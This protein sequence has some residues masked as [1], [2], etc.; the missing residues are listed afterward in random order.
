MSELELRFASE[1]YDRIRPLADG[2]VVPR[3]LALGYVRMG[4][5]ELFDRMARDRD[6]HIAEMSLSTYLNFRSRDIDE[7][8]ALPVFTSRVFRHGFI[9]V[10]ADSGIAA[11]EDLRGVRVGTM[12]YQ[13]TSNLWTRGFL[14]DDYGITPAD[15]TWYLGG[16]EE[17]GATER[18]PVAIPDDVSVERIPPEA[19]LCDLLV[20]GEIDA[21]FAPHTPSCFHERPD[22]IRRLFPD[23]R[24]VEQEY[25]RRTGFFPIMHVVVVRRD[26]YDANP[27]VAESLF[28]AFREAKHVAFDRLRFSGSAAAMLPWLYADVE[29]LDTVF[30]GHYWPYGVEA[31]RSELE[32]M[33]RYAMEQGIAVRNLEVDELF[34]PETLSLTCT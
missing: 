27:W 2:S 19:T 16:Q 25:H 11:P 32:T 4:H 6:F 24:R 29:E 21:M 10:G 28:E 34:A 26:V 31:N 33:I 8:V 5:G 20:A 17:P 7:L 13:L 22:R 30:D 14:K 18:A 15:F 1:I 9:F 23:H 3:G 12:Q